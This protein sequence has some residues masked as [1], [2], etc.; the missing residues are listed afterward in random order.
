MTRLFRVLVLTDHTGHSDQNSIYA[1]LNQMLDH[2]SCHSIDVA[3]RGLKRNTLF[4]TGMQRDALLGTALTAE[5]K[6]TVSGDHYKTNLR[7]LKIKEYDIV[8]LRLPRPVSDELLEWVAEVFSQAFVIN[9]PK[10]IIAT[11]NKKFL[12]NFPEICPDVRLCY[13][14]QEI[15]QE[16][17]KY[18]IVLK[19]L[20]DYGGRGLLKIDGDTIDDGLKEYDTSLYL[21]TLKEKITSEGYL[22]MR[23]LK[24][25]NQGDKRILVVDGE[26]LAAFLRLPKAGAWLCN[27]AQGGKSE[28]TEV[29]QK[30]RDII[31]HINPQLQAQGIFMY[32]ADTLV[33]DNG[34][35]VLSEINTLSVGGYLHSELQKGRP[36]IKKLLDKIFEH[37]DQRT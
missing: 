20:K 36:I 18:P 26:I 5:F 33:D 35:R 34:E 28:T 15:K 31:S 7:K 29:T 6:Y 27:I 10:G 4:Y 2:P 23:Y 12:I 9:S 24:N 3:S 22:S 13:T 11:S 37:A 32:G 21:D 8:L 25:V 17:A 19:P 30:E 16:I 14:M 1:I